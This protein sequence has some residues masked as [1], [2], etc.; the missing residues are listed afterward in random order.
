MNKQWYGA[1]TVYNAYPNRVSDTK[2]Y[3]ERIIVLLATSSDEAI[4]VAEEE[5][6]NYAKDFGMLYLGYVNVFQLLEETI[7]N[8]SEVY[9][10]LRES[11]LDSTQYLNSFFDTGG[12]KTR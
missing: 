2:I 12:E 3:E 1:R 11:N 7:K 4:K 8:K 9:S 10:L 6:N 5:A